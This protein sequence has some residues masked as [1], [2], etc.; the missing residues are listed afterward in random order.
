MRSSESKTESNIK[1]RCKSFLRLMYRCFFVRF[2]EYC[3]RGDLAEYKCCCGD[4]AEE[5]SCK[6][7]RE[8]CCLILCDV[9]FH[10]YLSFLC[11]YYRLNKLKKLPQTY[12]KR[13]TLLLPIYSVYF[14]SVTTGYKTVMV[15]LELS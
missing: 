6:S 11:H 10:E 13:A 8:K 4:Q 2:S 15:L 12:Y 1:H 14:K 5:S 9:V 7:E 3:R